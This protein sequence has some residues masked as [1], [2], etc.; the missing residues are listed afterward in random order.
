MMKLWTVITIV[1]IVVSVSIIAELRLPV[2]GVKLDEKALQD[3]LSV[4]DNRAT[5]ADCTS[6]ENICKGHEE[7]CSNFCGWLP[8]APRW[9]W[10]RKCYPADSGYMEE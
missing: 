1:F 6:N 2:N 10:Y 4:P 3:R 9:K 7:C 5:N 8:A